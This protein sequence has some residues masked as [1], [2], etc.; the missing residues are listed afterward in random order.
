MSAI[1]K[2]ILYSIRVL[3]YL[4]G[5]FSLARVLKP[6]HENHLIDK[7]TYFIYSKKYLA[8]SLKVKNRLRIISFHYTFIKE[9]FN[10]SSLE[11]IFTCGLKC[12]KED[13]NGHHFNV[14][15]RYSGKQEYE[16]AWSLIFQIC[17][18]P[19]YRLSFT[20]GNGADF[21]CSADTVIYV[22]RLQGER[23][24][25]D[26]IKEASKLLG[27]NTPCAILLKILEVIGTSL[28]IKTIAGVSNKHQISINKRGFQIISCD[29]NKVWEKHGG[30]EDSRG[31][32]YFMPCPFIKKSIH[33]VKPKLRKRCLAKRKKLED[34]YNQAFIYISPFIVSADNEIKNRLI[35]AG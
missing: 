1:L 3:I 34:I 29:Y 9:V 6:F 32:F 17:N 19:I 25:Y 35:S 22:S 28:N 12:W 7:S 15:L 18:R 20:F 13:L 8:R 27:N 5:H 30:I 11:K 16:G 23:Y 24:Q 4:R 14:L 21:G 26:S 31:F 10:K 2:S 33:L